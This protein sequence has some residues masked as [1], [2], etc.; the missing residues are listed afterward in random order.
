[1]RGLCV[2]LLFAGC[3]VSAD[4][5]GAQFKCSESEPCQSGFECVVG[6]CQ[7]EGSGNGD[8]SVDA[9]A[10][11]SAID[12][13]PVVCLDKIALSDD[14]EDPAVD[15]QWNDMAQPNAQVEETGG[16][17][18]ITPQSDI[19]TPRHAWYRSATS[20]DFTGRRVF[21]EVPQMVNP[22]TPAFASFSLGV[23]GQGSYFISQQQGVLLFGVMVGTTPATI[24]V[25][26][27]DSTAHRFWQLR[28]IDNTVYAD[29]SADGDAWTEL[30]STAVADVTGNFW[31]ELRGGTDERVADPGVVHFDNVNVGHD[32]P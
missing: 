15:P 5:S 20:Y 4:Y 24:S 26:T 14:F 1:M 8:A 23:D 17:L 32:C 6:V 16:L 7:P 3:T 29:V 21:V 22:A 27:Y 9:R 2:A 13:M 30:G 31:V 25:E 10:D 18:V 11:A 28:R 19:A 12:A